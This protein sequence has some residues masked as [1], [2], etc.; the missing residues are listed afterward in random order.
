MRP[1]LPSAVSV[2]MEEWE[3]AAGTTIDSQDTIGRPKEGG[4][5]RLLLL[6]KTVTFNP[7]SQQ[8]FLII[9]HVH[10]SLDI[11]LKRSL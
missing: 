2:L 9:A 1:P 7:S 11:K 5:G 3:E 6:W 4:P 10:V 8:H